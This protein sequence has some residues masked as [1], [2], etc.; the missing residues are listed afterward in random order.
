MWQVHLEPA[1][2]PMPKIT[3]KTNST[4][5]NVLYPMRSQIILPD[6]IQKDVLTSSFQKSVY[7]PILIKE[8]SNVVGSNFII[9]FIY[10][11]TPK[12]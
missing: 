6:S 12:Y 11:L 4:Y 1:L 7:N 2:L 9:P 10:T 8:K 5:F 3:K